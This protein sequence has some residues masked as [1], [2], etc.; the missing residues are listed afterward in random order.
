MFSGRLSSPTMSPRLSIAKPN[1]VAMTT[2]LRT[3]A[4]ASP[5]IS[6]LSHAP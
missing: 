3:G 4:S 2:F 5:T 1:L 6:S